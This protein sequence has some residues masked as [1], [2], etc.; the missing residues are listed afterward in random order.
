MVTLRGAVTSINGGALGSD[1]L[2]SV[3]G[4]P[5]K[6]HTPTDELLPNLGFARVGLGRFSAAK[7]REGPRWL[8]LI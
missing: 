2:L 6:E 4:L 5:M 8:M 7:L 1:A 3:A